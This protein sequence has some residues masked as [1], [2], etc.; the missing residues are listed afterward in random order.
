[1][2]DT[3]D[4]SDASDVS[5]APLKPPT[6]YDVAFRAGVS[7]QTVS[8]VVKGETN[9]RADLRERIEA[10]IHEL[11]YKPNMAARALASTRRTRIAAVI[12]DFLEIGPSR[13]LKGASDHAKD[14]GYLLDIVSLD[15]SDASTLEGALAVLDPRDLAGVLVIA[16]SD[17]VLALIEQVGFSGPVYIEPE[18]TGVDLA[19]AHNQATAVLID[20]LLSLGHRRFFHVAGPLAWVAAR[21][22]DN[23]YL[24]MLADAGAESLGTLSGD[25]SAESGYR[26]AM[27]V[28]LDAGITAVVAGND[29]MALGVMAA[30]AD[31]GVRVPEDVSVA[32]F[33]DIPESSYFRPA[34]TTVRLDFEQHGRVI[35]G[36]LLAQIAGLDRPP[37]ELPEPELI[38][39][40]STAARG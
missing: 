35:M 8:R 2:S 14:S 16:P 13:I 4:T 5:G 9:I 32:G 31:R 40:K 25:W 29:Q 10:A 26:A 11:G 1:M 21:A 15:P 20:H 7:H 17:P 36:R 39:R 38:V 30:L 22:R 28:P 19:T 23:T 37:L 18:N 24:A 6:L 27:S 12:Y 34:L 3:S 33:D